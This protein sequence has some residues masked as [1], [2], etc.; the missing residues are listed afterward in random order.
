MIQNEIMALRK[1]QHANIVQLFEVIQES[2][3]LILIMEY[4]A[5]DDLYS[6]IKVKKKLPEI[7]AAYLMRGVMQA[8]D[9]LHK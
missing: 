5:G 9:E 4:I 1:V 2:D 3:R 6:F 7:E 8:L